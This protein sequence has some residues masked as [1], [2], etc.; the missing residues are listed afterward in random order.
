MERESKILWLIGIATVLIIGLG[1]YF[2]SKPP[3]PKSE[4]VA[5]KVDEKLLVK[6]DSNIKKAANEKAV[7]VEF[8]DFQCPACGTYYPVVKQVEEAYSDTLTYV[9]RN[10]PLSQHKNA[11]PAANAAEAAGI[12]GKYWDM[13]D[14]IYTTQSN[15]SA[16]GDPE[17]IFEGYAKDLNLDINKFKA[18]SASKEVKDKVQGDYNDG[19]TLGVNSTPSF[20]LNGQKLDPPRSFDEFKSV[21]NSVIANASAQPDVTGAAETYHGHF[22][23][24]II[25]SGKVV[26][27][28]QKKYQSTDGND[29]NEWIHMH[30]G[31]GEIVH[32][33][34]KG[35]K[36]ADLFNSLKIGFNNECFT[37]DTGVKYCTGN[38]KTLKMFVN[39]KENK[40]FDNYIPADLDR[41]LIT[42]GSEEGT[43]LQKQIDSVT[44][45]ACIY[46]ET[47]PERGKPP[48]EE[49]IGGLG[50]GCTKE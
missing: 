48:T 30:D 1:A 31:N 10:F 39:G 8:G 25:L 21:I 16:S 26:D 40:D 27:L 12:Q 4:I 19:V 50:T 42:Y 22:D 49:C 23:L 43:V 5:N 7:L 35:M 29:L 44:D 24:K 38:G 20:Y 33:H 13:V 47:C 41:I 32:V 34:K 15:W 28:A 37:L 18:D 11:L 6:A 36:L 9:F 14:K 46:S 17:K 2:L 3:K 45:K